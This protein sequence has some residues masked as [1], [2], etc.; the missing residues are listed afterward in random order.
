MWSDWLVFCD[1]DFQSVCPLMEKDKKLMEASWLETLRG[2]LCLILMGGAMLSKS[3]IQ[4]SVDG[5]GCVPSLLFDLR[6]SY[7]GCNEDNGDLLQKVPCIHCYTQ[8]PQ[9]CSRPPLTHA[10][11]RDYWT[12]MGKSVSVSCGVIVSFSWVLVHTRFCLW[13]SKRSRA[14]ANSFAKR[15]HWS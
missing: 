9:P 12:L 10:S 4:F 7:G 2:K 14:K 15:T 8:C 5:Q 6:P 1:C 3:L 11:A 13:P